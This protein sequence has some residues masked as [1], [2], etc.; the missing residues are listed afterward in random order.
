M[1]HKGVVNC[2]HGQPMQRNGTKSGIG[3]SGIRP[4]RTPA[5]FIILILD[6]IFTGVATAVEAPGIGTF[7]TPLS[8]RCT[9][10]SPGRTSGKVPSRLSRP[11]SWCCGSSPG[12]DPQERSSPRCRS[13]RSPAAWGSPIR[14]RRSNSLVY[15]AKPVV[16]GDRISC[17]LMRSDESCRDFPGISLPRT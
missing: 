7:S 11:W 8:R 15:S 16:S 4:R 6:V 14:T 1:H 12:P 2:V 9:V 13:G 10:T 17:Q 3:C 5:L